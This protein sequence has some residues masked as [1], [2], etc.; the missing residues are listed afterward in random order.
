MTPETLAAVRAARAANR[1]VVLLTWLKDGRQQLVTA[2]DAPAELAPAVARAL[3]SDRAEVVGDGL[4]VEPFNPP[5]RLIIVGAVHVSAPLAAMAR[6]AGF[7][8]VIVEPRRAWATAERFPGETLVQTWPDEALRELAP[9]AR[10]AVVT[11]TH[12]PKL[13]DP[14]LL[15]ALASP[16]F[17]IGCLGSPKTHASRLERL[18][19]A[20][21]ARDALARLHGPIGLPIHARSPA[22]IAV[23]I[24]AEIV[25]DLRKGP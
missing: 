10:T 15:E 8:V 11:L 6:L 24:M 2:G 14:A 3:S 1:A 20:G 21:V 19:E 4:F 25:S 13:D 17:Y 18:A 5:L 7:A 23:S 9:D 22:E 16:A 12:D